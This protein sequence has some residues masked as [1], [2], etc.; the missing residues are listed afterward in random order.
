MGCGSSAKGPPSIPVAHARAERIEKETQLEFLTELRQDGR[1]LADYCLHLKESNCRG[2]LIDLWAL[3]LALSGTWGN[4]DKTMKAC[5]KVAS[6]L[7]ASWD[8]YKESPEGLGNFDDKHEWAQHDFPGEAVRR[9]IGEHDKRERIGQEHEMYGFA[10]AAMVGVHVAVVCSNL[11]HQFAMEIL[12]TQ[13][14]AKAAFKER[15]R[16]LKLEDCRQ[17]MIRVFPVPPHGSAYSPHTCLDEEFEIEEMAPTLFAEVRKVTGINSHEFFESVCRTDF[18][19]ISF[20]TNSKSG[21]FFFFSHDEKYLLKTT[22]EIEA[23]TLVEMLPQYLDRLRGEPRTMLGRYLGLY[24]LHFEDTSRLF[25]IM[26][27]VTNHQNEI[28]RVYDIKGSVHNRTAKPGDS[29][30]KDN[31]FWEEMGETLSIPLPMASEIAEVHRVDVAFLQE[32]RIMDFSL[33]LQIHDKTGEFFGAEDHSLT[34]S[35]TQAVRLMSS[36]R[37]PQGTWLRMGQGSD[38]AAGSPRALRQRVTWMPNDG[39]IVRDDGK[40]LYTFGLIDM[41]VPFNTYPKLQYVGE[42]LVS[43]G[44]GFEYS[45]VPPEYYCSRQIEKVHKM[46]GVPLINGGDS[47]VE[48]ED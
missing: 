44:K 10:V 11:I 3:D 45:R 41:L 27:A 13:D 6:R 4:F 25:F 15:F 42:E 38:A 33:L 16:M 32:F 39:T 22:T 5:K 31:N 47:E 7:E 1:L 19:F 23:K 48:S 36:D 46:C 9:K 40:L 43:C 12:G 8:E 34:K 18:E 35:K 29:I 17:K 2:E 37:A 28:S 26:R 20:G 30:G 21:E 14:S 24:R